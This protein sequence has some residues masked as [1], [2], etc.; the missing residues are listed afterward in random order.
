MSNSEFNDFGFTIMD[1]YELDAVQDAQQV[2]NENSTT[3][4]ELED[5]LN[6]LYNA[7]KPL[8][9]NLAKNPE[10]SYIYWPDRL[11]KLEAFS[12]M[13]DGIYKG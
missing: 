6:R 12:D 3:V 1:E 13:I 9:N 10:K 11:G 4:G 8:L 2:A 5:K 7:Y